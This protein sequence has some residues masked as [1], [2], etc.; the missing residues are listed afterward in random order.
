[1][2]GGEGWEQGGPHL[3]GLSRGPPEFLVTPLVAKLITI[4]M[5]ITLCFIM[6]C[7]IIS[8]IGLPHTHHPASSKLAIGRNFLS[9]TKFYNF[10]GIRSAP[11]DT[12]TLPLEVSGN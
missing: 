9:Y 12:K 11:R 10:D 8:P 5:P 7:C 3:D 2:K 1:M 4:A 6:S